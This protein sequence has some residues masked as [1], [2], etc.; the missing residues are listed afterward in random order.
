MALLHNRL[1][2][3]RQSYVIIQCQSNVQIKK[4]TLYK[5]YRDFLL[6][7]PF[8]LH[9]LLNPGAHWLFNDKPCCK[10]FTQSLL[11]FEMRAYGPYS[12]FEFVMLF[13]LAEV[14]CWYFNKLPIHSVNVVE[15]LQSSLR[16][17]YV[18]NIHK[19]QIIRWCVTAIADFVILLHYAL[20]RMI[21]SR[22]WICFRVRGRADAK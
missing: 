8:F 18:L 16:K 17:F 22:F 21:F 12:Y 19:I 11:T 6:P 10:H 5:R 15:Y 2:L 1:K 3:K 7:L 14:S 20:R 9:H 13:R 4:K